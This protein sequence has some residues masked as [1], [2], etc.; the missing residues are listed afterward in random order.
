MLPPQALCWLLASVHC[1]SNRLF[2][3]M[4]I[5]KIE[6]LVLILLVC[7]F[8]FHLK[9]IGGY[10]VCCPCSVVSLHKVLCLLRP[11]GDTLLFTQKQ[12]RKKVES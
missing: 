12:P 7:V 10:L 9:N 3:H 4:L 2:I 6:L 8:L 11:V 1:Y 5:F